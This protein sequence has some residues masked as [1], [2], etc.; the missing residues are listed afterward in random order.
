[1]SLRQRESPA[2]EAPVLPEVRPPRKTLGERAR[3]NPLSTM[4][5]VSIDVVAT[6]VGIT[7]GAWWAS[8]TEEQVPPPLLL[9]LYVILGMAFFLVR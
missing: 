9:A 8:M 6:T 1:M 7:L 5:T 2:V 4:I 3:T